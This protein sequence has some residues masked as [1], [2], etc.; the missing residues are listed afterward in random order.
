MEVDAKSPGSNPG[1][2][3]RPQSRDARIDSSMFVLK[4]GAR[5]MEGT[6]DEGEGDENIDYAI[7]LKKYMDIYRNNTG[8][9]IS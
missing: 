5:S 7:R 9:Q 8:C 3:V 1:V 2:G 6:N 4:I